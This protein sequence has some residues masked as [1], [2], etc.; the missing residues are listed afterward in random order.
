MQTEVL[1]VYVQFLLFAARD[2]PETPTKLYKLVFF[3]RAIG[4]KKKDLQIYRLT[5]S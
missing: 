3:E 4:T 1:F 5:A 2:G